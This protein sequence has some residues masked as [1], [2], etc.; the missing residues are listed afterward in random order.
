MCCDAN[1]LSKRSL[2]RRFGKGKT[3]KLWKE[4]YPSGRA[5]ISHYQ[6]S[7]GEHV[8]KVWGN[9]LW[10]GR[11]DRGSPSGIHVYRRK[12]GKWFVALPVVVRKEDLVCAD[13]TQAV[14]RK[15]RILKK[16]WVAAGLPLEKKA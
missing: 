9:K 2:L 12:P 8:A 1:E 15:V 6:Y 13:S 3:L 5:D 10:T 4:L 7:P 16:D 11:Y 14:F